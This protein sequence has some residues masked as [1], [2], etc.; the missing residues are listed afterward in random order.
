MKLGEF[1]R[2]YRKAKRMSVRVMSEEIG[3]NQFRLQK[4]EGGI[5]PKSEDLD[6][7]KHYFKLNIVENISEDFL[8]SCIEGSFPSEAGDKL[9]SSELLKQKDLLIEEK[10]KRIYELNQTITLLKEALDL[11][12]KT[13]KPTK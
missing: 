13:S 6:K 12:K 5:N 10:D 11:Y 1:L 7:I 9:P 2:K 3:V 4:W 8:N